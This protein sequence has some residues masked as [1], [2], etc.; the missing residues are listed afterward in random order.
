MGYTLD[1][2]YIYIYVLYISIVYY[3]MYYTYIDYMKAHANW[4]LELAIGTAPCRWIYSRFA[5]FGS[6]AL[7]SVHNC[8]F[9]LCWSMLFVL[10]G[11]VFPTIFHDIMIYNMPYIF[12]NPCDF[13]KNHQ[14][15]L[16]HS[17]VSTRWPANML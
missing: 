6:C 2:I 16:V 7:A 13:T 12:T 17:F 4:P 1:Y 15:P 9:A 3:S 5:D 10:G 14:H 8:V 11:C